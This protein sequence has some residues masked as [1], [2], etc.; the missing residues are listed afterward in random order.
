MSER[1]RDFADGEFFHIYNRGVDKRIVFTD[2]YDAHRFLKSLVEFNTA[3]PIGSL[4]ENSFRKRDELGGETPKF[5]SDRRL[6]NIIVYCLNPNH[7]HLILEQLTDGGISE[8]M[9][10]LSGGYTGYF[11]NKY[12]RTGALF[13][14][15]FKDRHINSNEYLLHV[16]AYINLNDRV[17]Q[18]GGETPKLIKSMT[19]W[20]EYIGE[21]NNGICEKKIILEQFKNVDE[22]KKFAFSSLESIL[23][24]K[25]ELKD[26]KD[27]LLE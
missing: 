19:S 11:N 6:V 3:D 24:R 4:Y 26:I 14:G 22:Y 13:Q 18:L 25:E 10:R 5:K 17:H 27:L 16:S 23:K 20:G 7:F 9:K 12:K 2:N 8:F 15:V 1:K 21:R